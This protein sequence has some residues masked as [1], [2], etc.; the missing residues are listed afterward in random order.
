ME[1]DDAAVLLGAH[2]H[3][4]LV[5]VG[6]AQRDVPGDCRGW[7]VRPDLLSGTTLVLQPRTVVALALIHI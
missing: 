3:G 1:A 6:D 5:L 7:R 4:Y 2:P